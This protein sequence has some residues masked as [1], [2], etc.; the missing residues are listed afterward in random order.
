MNQEPTIS[1]PD[2][3]DFAWL[4]AQWSDGL[5]NAITGMGCPPPEIEISSVGTEPR[6]ENSFW[7]AQQFN[8]LAETAVW[9]GAAGTAWNQI[10]ERALKAIGVEE[11]APNDVRDTYREILAQ[12]FS[13][14]A[15]ALSARCGR[16]VT[17]SH[18]EPALG[19]PDAGGRGF[20]NMRSGDGPPVH[21]CFAAGV[22]F[23]RQLDS[24]APAK[25]DPAASGPAETGDANRPEEAGLGLESLFDIEM[26]IT[27]SFGTAIL[28]LEVVLRLEA[29]STVQLARAPYDPVDLRVN[30]RIL[31][32]GE[33]VIV[34]GQYGVRIQ[35]L[36]GRGAHLDQISR[37][38]RTE[39]GQISIS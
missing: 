34:K 13:A 10:G 28:P 25:P 27:V 20:I 17:C 2:G 9:V 5:A 22:N 39:R 6:D 30:G 19:I 36:S 31:A 26:P 16:E 15:T 37:R 35:E 18:G 12:S 1:N 24:P 8:V 21:F 29:G 33:I 14:L 3:T 4:L 32:R 38:P 7:W 23:L 11:P